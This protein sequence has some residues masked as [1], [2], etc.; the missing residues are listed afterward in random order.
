MVKHSNTNSTSDSPNG[1]HVL[2]FKLFYTMLM[3]IIPF[4][5]KDDHV[6]KRARKFNT[7]G[8]KINVLHP[9]KWQLRWK[10]YKYIERVSID[11]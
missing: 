11:V 2:Q 8:V 5:N 9:L 7:Q 4:A 3:F 1:V 10:F 6:H